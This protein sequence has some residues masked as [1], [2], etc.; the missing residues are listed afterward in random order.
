MQ[1]WALKYL[2]W[3][4][5]SFPRSNRS[6]L[7]YFKFATK[8][9]SFFCFMDPHTWNAVCGIK[10]TIV[11]ICFSLQEKNSHKILTSFVLKT[12]Y[13]SHQTQMFWVPD[14]VLK[15]KSIFSPQFHTQVFLTL[16]IRSEL[17][18]IAKNLIKNSVVMWKYI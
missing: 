6:V 18:W 11:C 12:N 4:C 5:V 9:L 8:I 2:I 3:Q 15:C 16:P 10:T 17:G 14:E 1:S 13:L 7:S